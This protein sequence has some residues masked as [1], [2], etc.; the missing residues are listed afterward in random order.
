MIM[1]TRDELIDALNWLDNENL[2]GKAFKTDVLSDMYLAS[3]K[4]STEV[5]SICANCLHYKRYQNDEP[6]LSCG[7]DSDNFIANPNR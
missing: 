4:S 3:I 2:I 5:E 1:I 7:D 6:C